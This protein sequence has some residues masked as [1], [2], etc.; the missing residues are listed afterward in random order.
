MIELHGRSII[1]GEPVAD[2]GRTFRA[3]NPSEGREFGPDFYEA[4]PAV[5]AGA[6]DTAP[7]PPTPRPP[8]GSTGRRAPRRSRA[9][10][11]PSREESRH[12]ATS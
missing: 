4:T 5:V 9:F 10:S 6:H 7:S 11:K 2:D 1:D 12:S 3:F 8:S